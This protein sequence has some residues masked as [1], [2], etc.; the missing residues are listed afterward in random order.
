MPHEWRVLWDLWTSGAMPATQCLAL[1]DALS[2]EERRRIGYRLAKLFNRRAHSPAR[3][4]AVHA[5][6]GTMSPQRLIAACEAAV[7]D[8]TM[9][10]EVANMLEEDILYGTGPDGAWKPL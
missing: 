5:L 2:S 1:W 7:Q 9:A 4:D 6:L 10:R 3:W 8:G